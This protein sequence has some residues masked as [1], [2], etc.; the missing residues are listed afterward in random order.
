[1]IDGVWNCFLP[2]INIPW[3]T[4]VSSLCAPSESVVL[5]ITL[6]YLAPCLSSWAGALKEQS[7]TAVS[8]IRTHE[9]TSSSHRFTR[10]APHQT[11]SCCQT[12]KQTHPNS[13]S[14]FILLDCHSLETAVNSE[15][16][17]RLYPVVDRLKHFSAVNL[18]TYLSGF[19]TSWNQ[20]I[21][22]HAPFRQASNSNRLCTTCGRP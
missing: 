7:H 20:Q 14:L 13:F 21:R 6:T 3:Q 15:H 16:Y 17:I 5:S 11:V 1:M 18:S 22:S 10:S 4:S 2:G 19:S 8:I 9:H 12:P